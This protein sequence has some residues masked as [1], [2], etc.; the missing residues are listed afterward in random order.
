MH[1]FPFTRAF[2]NERRKFMK[3]RKKLHPFMDHLRKAKKQ[4]AEF[5]S[6]LAM[7][8]EAFNNGNV[9]RAFE[10]ALRAY[11]KTESTTLICRMMAA[12]FGRPNAYQ[13]IEDTMLEVVPVKIGFTNEGWFCTFL[14]KQRG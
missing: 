4:N 1:D 11:E 7:A 3:Q 13:T 10:Y 9:E 6:W 5:C 12:Y 2:K 14:D 8:E